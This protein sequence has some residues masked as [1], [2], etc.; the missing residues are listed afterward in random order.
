MVRGSYKRTPKLHSATVS[1]STSAELRYSSWVAG[2]GLMQ[3]RDAVVRTGGRGSNR[4]GQVR[5][6]RG[7]AEERCLLMVGWPKNE[8][9]LKKMAAAEWYFSCCAGMST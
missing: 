6:G 1:G 7:G 8:K 5:N 2:R 4:R 3:P 9:G